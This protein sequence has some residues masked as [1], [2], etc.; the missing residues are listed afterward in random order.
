M[1][2]D[3]N[4]LSARLLMLVLL[5][6]AA[7]PSPAL[8]KATFASTADVAIEPIPGSVMST[9]A[10]SNGDR[11]VLPGSGETVRVRL[12]LPQRL[13]DGPWR[14]WL[15]R[16]M[17]DEVWIESGTWRSPSRGFFMPGPSESL[18][19][20]G[21]S[22]AL[23]EGTRP[24]TIDL[25]VRSSDRVTLRPQ[26][27]AH[28]ETARV[29][30]R[31]GAL[32]SAIYASLGVLALV[33]LSLYLAV[34]DRDYLALLAFIVSALVFLLAANGHL[35]V[36]PGLRVAGQWGVQGVWA[37]LLAMAAASVWL[38]G[39]Y[40]ELRSNAPRLRR[41]GGYLM[42]ALLVLAALCLL[43][44]PRLL[45]SMRWLSTLGWLG[46][47]VYAASAAVVAI[48]HRLWSSL[49]IALLAGMLVLA[50][51]SHALALHGIG[52][53]NFWTRYGYQVALAG[54]AFLVTMGMVGRIAHVRAERDLERL[55]HSDSERR[56]QR[57]AARAAFVLNLRQRL[58]EL[59]P[60][61]M[62]WVA[63]RQVYECLQPLLEL[64]AGALVAHGYH[65]FE[66]MLAEPPSSKLRY[67]ALLSTH[68]NMLRDLA[69]AHS[70]P[71]QL[72]L[73][74]AEKDQAE[75]DQA[76]TDRNELRS[77][78]AVVPLPMRAPAW[79]VLLLQ[80]RGGGE[81]SDDEL[82][83]ASAFG[84]VAVAHADEA[85][86]AANLRR[87]AEFDA[88]TG[89]H[90]RRTID[91]WLARSFGEAHRTGQP[92]SVLFVDLDHF[93]VINDTH[94][95][96]CGDACLRH[97]SAIL[98]RELEPNDL[99]GRYGG[100]EFLVVLPGRDVN[101]ARQ[102]GERM[103]AA[104]E[105]ATLEWNGQPIRLTASIGV[106]PRWEEEHTSAA[107]VERADKALYAAKR[108]G[109]NQVRVA[110]AEFG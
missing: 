14:L 103:R 77:W 90:N 19:P 9:Q 52:P 18:F 92:L 108:S 79:G 56:L 70:P 85:A 59:P 69:R 32:A 97:V 47:G 33:A 106:A 60:G 17:L 68:D 15:G 84:Q 80:R 76:D 55:A 62:E 51:G 57:E 102:V 58:R 91:L 20:A 7:W 34:R 23:P 8:A 4:M 54:Y 29:Q 63:F 89:T 100:E 83:L 2:P 5:G 94:G 37:L 48:R 28:A 1:V 46:A 82:A 66:L 11:V 101:A 67:T 107:A 64:E 96:A 50:W 12:R 31:M 45:A 10:V 93:K 73:E 98:R 44:Q 99:L 42:T 25:V 86:N 109:R 6:S 49:P 24:A 3:L 35:Y 75:K 87:S 105:R 88:L 27:R 39:L 36:M 110:P 65:G 26:L 40:A 104:V 22:F 30:Q 53:D 38:A 74:Q 78:H 81:F 16:D 72:Q 61:D 21:Y 43:D 41:F 13:G 71:V 95:H